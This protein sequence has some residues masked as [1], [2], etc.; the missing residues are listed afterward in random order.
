MGSDQI[1]MLYKPPGRAPCFETTVVAKLG[2]YNVTWCTGAQKYF[3]Y[4]MK[5]AAVK[6]WKA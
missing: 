3:L 2:N 5:E 1:S 4:G 6:R